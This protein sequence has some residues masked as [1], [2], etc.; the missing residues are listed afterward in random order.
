MDNSDSRLS[1]FSITG[2]LKVLEV[3]ALTVSSSSCSFDFNIEEES[4]LGSSNCNKTSKESRVE[5][6]AAGL[7]RVLNKESF[8]V[9]NRKYEGIDKGSV[10]VLSLP[11]VS[12][13]SSSS[14]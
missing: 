8:P 5:A 4:W 3:E 9:S 2:S 12:V 11:S 1:E 14:C 10:L 6:A 13:P 7:E